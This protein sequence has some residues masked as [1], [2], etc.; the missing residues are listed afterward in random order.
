MVEEIEFCSVDLKVASLLNL[1]QMQ[2]FGAICIDFKE[3]VLRIALLE[4]KEES[5][6]ILPKI[7]SSYKIHFCKISKENFQEVLR[8]LQIEQNIAHLLNEIPKQGIDSEDSKIVLLLENILQDAIYKGASDI[9][10]EQTIKECKIRFRLDSVLV[11]RLVLPSYLNASLVLCLKLFSNLNIAEVSLPQDGRFSYGLKNIKGEVVS[12]DFRISTLPLV[13]GE[14]VV[15][16]VLDPTSVALPLKELG[17]L[18]KE[19]QEILKLANLP[20]G[21]VLVSGPTGSGKSTTLHAILKQI[22]HKNLKIISLEDPVEYRLENITQVAIHKEMSFASVL[23]SILRQDPDVIMVGEIRDKE[24]L[25]VALRAAFTGHLVFSTLHT[26]DALETIPRLI[27]MGV[28]PY[29]LKEALSGVIAQRLLRR[30]CPMCKNKEGEFYSAKGCMRCNFT[31]FKDRIV[32]AEILIMDSN[33]KSFIDGKIA[34]DKL[35]EILQKEGSYTL[36]QKALDKA[37]SGITSL[38]EVYRA[39]K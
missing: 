24:T 36:L 13:E 38:K 35:L 8:F 22:Q 26:N 10:I 23:K 18:E 9:H 15:L 19:L 7:L 12:Y 17:F 2:H 25:K 37:K 29:F 14:S 34:K 28:E 30:L 39:V 31:G 3:E 1:E 16:R 20:Y 21:F 33:L 27:D 5:V 6:K 32:V 11:D 4:F